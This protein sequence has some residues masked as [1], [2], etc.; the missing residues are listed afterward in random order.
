MK[1][2]PRLRRSFVLPKIKGG[3]IALFLGIQSV[4]WAYDHMCPTKVKPPRKPYKPKET[5]PLTPF[6]NEPYH[7]QARAFPVW[8]KPFPCG[9]LVNQTD[10]GSRQPTTSGLLYI[11]E[12][13]TGSTTLSGVT[14]RIARNMAQRLHHANQTTACTS[15]FVHLRARRLRDRNPHESFLWSIV[16]EPTTRIISKFFHFAVSRDGVKPTLPKFQKYVMDNEVTDQAYYFKSL[17]MRPKLNPYRLD[18]FPLFLEQLLASYD[19]L[20]VSERMDES[21]VVLQLLLGLETQDILYLSTKT[22]GS[23][24]FFPQQQKCVLIQKSKV[25]PEMKEW[26]YSE[27]FDVFL[28]ADVLV[29]KAANASLDRTIDSLGRDRVD[30]ALKRLQWAQRLAQETCGAVTKFPC[31][32]EGAR[33]PVT[34]CLQQDVACGYKCLDRVGAALAK[35]ADFQQLQAPS[36]L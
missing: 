5:D 16:R 8:Q 11:K 29:Y 32:A 3:F 6:Y 21:L 27:D 10:M 14:V 28:Q 13:K 23:Y 9:P 15:R 1:G 4:W 31:T 20:G 25:T 22:S 19:F 24:E 17:S 18:L 36:I 12:M 34:D 35:N 30:K 7:G 2:H 26:F 33:E